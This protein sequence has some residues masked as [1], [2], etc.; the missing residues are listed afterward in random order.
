MPAPG[1][2]RS[3]ILIRPYQDSDHEQVFRILLEGFWPVGNRLFK[4]K[5][6]RRTVYIQVVLSSFVLALLTVWL[7][8]P[9]WNAPYWSTI[10]S[11][12]VSMPKT[13]VGFLSKRDFTTIFSMQFLSSTFLTAWL[14]WLAVIGTSVAA[15]Y[16]RQCVY[17]LAAMYVS[18][19]VEDD[20]SN[21]SGYYQSDE[22]FP[23]TQFYENNR[24]IMS[25]AEAQYKAKEEKSKV[26][27][28][29]NYSQFWVACL[30]LHPQL[31][32][33]C[34]ALDDVGFHSAYLAARQK[35]LPDEHGAVTDPHPKELELRRMSVQSA[36]RR[37]G[38]FSMLISTMKEHAR[39]NGFHKLTLST[40][41]LQVEAIGGYKKAGFK[42]KYVQRMGP[43]F[44]IWFAEMNLKNE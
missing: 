31:V 3:E 9:F 44:G 16:Y 40:T 42:E 41:L 35:V 10:Q 33:G 2:D 5:L 20:M 38:I 4:V 15:F 26:A 12:L 21:L 8:I 36:Y 1:I 32:M 11:I 18:E 43:D 22:A 25:Q 30:R 7:F 24:D 28:K 14:I 27:K 19:S 34:G 13:T 39:E 37:L 23:K 29:K 17:G 6:F